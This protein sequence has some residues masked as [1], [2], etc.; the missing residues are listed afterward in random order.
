MNADTGALKW[1]YHA[2]SPVVA[3]ITL[4]AGGV[5]FSGDT[6][7]RFLVLDSTTGRELYH[8]ALQGAAGAG[9]VSYVAGGKQYV[10][11]GSGPTLRTT[12]SASGVPTITI[13][14]L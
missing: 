9:V 1:R 3:G 14:S 4:T 11:G 10:A 7:G 12:F 5:I 6:G 13:F 2:T 8:H